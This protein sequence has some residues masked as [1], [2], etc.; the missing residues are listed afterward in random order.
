[1]LLTNFLP[2]SSG[3]P[4]SGNGVYKLHAIALNK[5]GIALDLGTRTI[6]VDNGHASKPFGTIDTPGQGGTVSGNTFV[7][8]GW[9]LTQN[10]YSI[11][12]DGST[13][14]VFVDGLP[15]G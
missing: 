12:F 1:M 13:L 4:A 11:P 14:T 8:F 7:N 15:L 5:D 9:A 2:S 10:P 3:A 6:S